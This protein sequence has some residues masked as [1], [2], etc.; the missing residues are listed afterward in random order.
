M[1]WNG[2]E[3]ATFDIET[4]SLSSPDGEFICSVFY[5]DNEYRVSENILELGEL[6][7]YLSK[8]K[9]Y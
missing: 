7:F 1:Y 6:F 8:D 4:T 9:H 2:K 5:D 3:I